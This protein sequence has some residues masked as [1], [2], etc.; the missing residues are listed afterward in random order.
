[1]IHKILFL[2][3]YFTNYG[4]SSLEYFGQNEFFSSFI[5]EIIEV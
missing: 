2:A 4:T 3:E 1:M 5:S